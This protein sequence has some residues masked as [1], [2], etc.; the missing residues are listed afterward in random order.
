MIPHGA[1]I[2]QFLY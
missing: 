2:L 1:S